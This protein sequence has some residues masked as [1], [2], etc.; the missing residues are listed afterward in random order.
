M[1]LLILCCTFLIFACNTGRKVTYLDTRDEETTTVDFG[2]TDL[3]RIS[4]TMVDSLLEFGPIV[5]MTRN[6]RPVVFV[7][8]IKNKTMEHIDL[9]SVTNSIRSGIIQSGK[10]RFVDMNKVD[11][12]H[13]QLRHQ[14]QLSVVD[15]STAKSFG[16]QV[17]ADL[18]LYGSLSSIEKQS[19]RVKDVYYKFTL[20]LM[21][22]E[23]GLIEWAGEK[24]IRK[25]GK[26]RAVG[27]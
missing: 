18:M 22:I 1:R 6:R 19:G 26:R 14:N 13:E 25:M 15:A 17:G 5:E 10:F 20:N 11:A 3:Q 7:D 9:E 12:L 8:Q 4:K 21:D 27:R 23:T 24:E 16:K 2:S